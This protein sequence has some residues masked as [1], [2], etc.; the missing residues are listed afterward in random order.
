MPETLS[1]TLPGCRKGI[2]LA[3]G[4]GTRL[5]PM[6]IPVSKQLLPVYDKPLIYYPLS[7]L[8]LAGIRDILLIGTPRDL[9]AF[10]NLL[11]DG[12]RWGVSF[13]YMAQLHP[14]GLP[15]AYVLGADFL[16]GERSLMMLGDNLLYGSYVSERIRAASVHD[17]ATLFAYRVRNPG[18]FGVVTLDAG[19]RPLA[20]VEKPA[21]PPSPWAVIGLY[22]M[23]GDAPHRARA[24]RPSARGETEIVELLGTY[25]AEGRL[26]AE[27]FGRGVS[28]LDTGT[29]H[30]LLQAAQFVEVLQ[31]RQGLQV[32]SPEEIAYRMGYI[33]AE[34]LRALAHPLRRTD[35][36]R[37][38]LRLSE[39]GLGGA[40]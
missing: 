10:E 2:L 20:L 29:P 30:A 36:G 7:V 1:P 21:H 19:G 17:G 5:Y 18:D 22:L 12:S 26:R 16:A 13:S 11:G 35:Y 23:D 4:A 28:W 31:E 37:Y 8:M 25:L 32:S 15:Q 3:A 34:E 24:L 14:D 40:L 33:D 38:L 39:E 9:P 27:L 6:T